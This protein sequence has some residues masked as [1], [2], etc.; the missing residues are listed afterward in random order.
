MA[1]KLNCLTQFAVG[2]KWDANGPGKL[3]VPAS[4]NAAAQA[5]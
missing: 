1:S 4:R 3:P 5:D 2:P